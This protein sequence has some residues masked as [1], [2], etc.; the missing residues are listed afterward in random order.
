MCK[1]Y[2]ITVYV[3][4]TVQFTFL[5]VRRWNITVATSYGSLIVIFAY[6]FVFSSLKLENGLKKYVR[7]V[8]EMKH[9]FVKLVVIFLLFTRHERNFN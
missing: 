8:A 2:S 5:L 6:N 1:C 7:N 4:D 3:N 9:G